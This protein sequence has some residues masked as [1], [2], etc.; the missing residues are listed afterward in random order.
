MTTY[1]IDC[2]Q[3]APMQG[4]SALPHAEPEPGLCHEFW[5]TGG[6][7]YEGVVATLSGRQ[8][9]ATNPQMCAAICRNLQLL[10][11]QVEVRTEVIA[12]LIDMYTLMP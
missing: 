3:Y 9:E 5:Q 12:L 7:R 1:K 10:L 11:L 4:G 6:S 2:R 8:G